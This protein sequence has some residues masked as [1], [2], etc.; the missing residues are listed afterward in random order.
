[1]PSPLSV[2]LRERVVAAVAGGASFH[3]AAARFGVSVSSA[4]RWSQR[5][6]QQGHVAP[7]PTHADDS[8]PAIEAHAD[9]ILSLNEAQPELFLRELRDALAEHGVQTST[10]G[11][12]RFFARHGITRKKGPQYAAEQERADV[13]AAREAWFEA[14]PDLD[15]D[16][17]VFLDETGAATNM[18]RR[19]GRAPRG[20]RCRLLVPQGHYKT[21]TVTAALRTTGL[22]AL[23]LADGATNGQRFRDYVANRL[24]PVLRPGDTV[25]LDNLQ[26]HKVSGIRERVEAAGARL[27]YLPPYSPEFNPIEQIFAKL[28][29]LL[30]TAAA[31]TV[32]DLWDAIR[33]AFT[34]FT[35]DEC[36]NCLAAAGY[37][38]DLAVAT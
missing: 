3:W 18:A 38:N 37:D 35:P 17:L 34:R 29:A 4:S 10:S 19:Y 30:R 11:L 32:A 24:V 27:L 33:N 16:K 6:A 8:L 2:D 14:Q 1:M 25:I 9:L 26:A 23:D 20:E 22:C 21:T 31:R 5:F 12:S 7:K 36:C 13:K 28:K 15:P